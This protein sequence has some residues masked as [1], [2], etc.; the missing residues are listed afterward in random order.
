MNAC[1][2]SFLCVLSIFG[3]AVDHVVSAAGLQYLGVNIAG[4][5]FGS[6]LPGQL[7]YPDNVYPSQY[8][9][10]YFKGKGMNIIRL[11]FQ[12]ER[13][14][15]PLNGPLNSIEF[16]LLDGFISAAT[17]KGMFVILD[18]HNY[19]RYSGNVI[20]SASVPVSAFTNFWG[21]LAEIYHTNNHVIFGLMNEPHD[22][23]TETWRDAA[24]A[25]IVAIRNTGAKNLILVPGNN[26]TGAGTWFYTYPNGGTPN[27]TVMLG[28]SDP[29]NN[30][31]FDVHQYLDPNQSGSTTNIVDVNI[32]VNRLSVFNQWCR[33]NH[34][35]GFLGEFAVANSTI[36]A[37]IGDEA[38][39]DVRYEPFLGRVREFLVKNPRFDDGTLYRPG[40]GLMTDDAYMTVPF[41]VRAWKA[42][43]DA[44]QLDGAVQQVL[45][46]HQRLF[47]Q[48]HGLLK[49]L[50]DLKSQQPAGQFWGRGN[51]WM[52]LAQVELLGAMPREHPRR[53]EVLAAF[54]RHMEGLRRCQDKD[55]GWH[56]VLDHPESW[57]ET[58]GTGM[59]VYGLARGV[60]EGWLDSSFADSA[61]K[62]WQA[63]ETKVTADG[64][65]VDVCGST[66]TGDLAYYLN[67]PRLNGDLHGYGSFLLA[68][69]EIVRLER[70]GRK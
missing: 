33:D 41:M 18:P 53:A 69:A 25:A 31:A 35:R 54:E 28:I 26:Y 12:W 19:A 45:G 48:E 40:K 59:F 52:V 68:G 64:D 56:Q 37:G 58:S 1:Q 3:L 43:G 4:A 49:H 9:V 67:R 60:N 16:T 13:L 55:G 10:D 38:T 7:Q 51:G 29:G 21:R 63:L 22:M 27:A 47:D 6:S 14:Q 17:T 24:N 32:G 70:M 42:T 65:L 44:R 57:I 11:P 2:K 23:S 5:E 61:R 66:D 39:K 20:G 46:T 36:G 50:W 62:G 34:R 30:Y 8:E 15:A